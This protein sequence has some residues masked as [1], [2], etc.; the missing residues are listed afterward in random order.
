MRSVDTAADSTGTPAG[1]SGTATPSADIDTSA[2][3][4]PAGPADL[5]VP[6]PRGELAEPATA[7]EVL[8][9][10]QTG[11]SGRVHGAVLPDAGLLLA[12]TRH[13]TEVAV[14]ALAQ[15]VRDSQRAVLRLVDEQERTPGGKAGPK[16]DDSGPQTVIVDPD[17]M[18]LTRE[19]TVAVAGVTRQRDELAQDRD[20]LVRH[21]DELTAERDRLRQQY[22]D[23]AH[24]L[25]R[26][27]AE[28]RQRERTLVDSP[29][30]VLQS[31]GRTTAPQPRVRTTTAGGARAP[32]SS[33]P[34]G[35]PRPPTALGRPP[36]V[37]PARRRRQHPVA[38]IVFV[39]ILLLV[40]A[41]GLGVVG[42]GLAT[43]RDPATVVR[44]LGRTVLGKTG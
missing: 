34:T 16:S 25:D 29:T 21:R 6:A 18:E 23:L 8:V 13:L 24:R 2:V 3:P 43:H 22:V 40:F 31:V 26:L 1:P 32:R 38:R 30:T 12:A 41:A 35:Q 39:L 19:L 27:E 5:P 9:L 14:P 7:G 15:Q 37:V 44:D 10:Y 36:R 20:R 4:A 28:R 33:R 17:D 42:A 11:E